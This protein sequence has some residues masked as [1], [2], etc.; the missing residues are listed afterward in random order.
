MN[1]TRQTRANDVART[2]AA[3]L[4]QEKTT[5]SRWRRQ[6]F[7]QEPDGTYSCLT[8][9]P[10]NFNIKPL[11]DEQAIAKHIDQE[12]QRDEAYELLTGRTLSH[13]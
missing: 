13:E 9:G 7:F 11:K 5:I 1:P 8:A 2:I 10:C 6:Q 3:E 12:L 4:R